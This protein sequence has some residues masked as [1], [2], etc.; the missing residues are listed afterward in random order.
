MRR[1]I[2]KWQSVKMTTIKNDKVKVYSTNLCPKCQNEQ[3][4]QTNYCSRCGKRLKK[5]GND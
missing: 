2:N 3:I 4:I 1:S 5:G